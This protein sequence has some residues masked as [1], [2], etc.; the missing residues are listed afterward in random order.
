[1]TRMPTCLGNLRVRIDS[2]GAVFSATNAT[3]CSPG[4]IWSTP[5]PD[6][7]TRR[8]TESERSRL[9]RAVEA[10]GLLAMPLVTDEGVTLDG[11]AEE[12]ELGQGTEIRK[13]RVVNRSPEP[14][15][16]ARDAILRAARVPR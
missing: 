9:R 15:V 14:F 11:V 12:I 10:S 2:G 4:E 3:E 1:M 8:L 7:P 6:A 13:V 16:A 5:Y